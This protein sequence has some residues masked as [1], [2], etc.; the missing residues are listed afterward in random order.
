MTRPSKTSLVL[1]GSEVKYRLEAERIAAKTP[2]HVDW[3]RFTV[4]RRNAPLLMV[5]P[6]LQRPFISERQE[7]QYL[8][9]A[10]RVRADYAD[11]YERNEVAKLL[12]GIPDCDH[13]APAQ[14]MELA[15][16]VAQALGSE[17]AVNPEIKKGHDFYKFR[18]AIE[19]S[20]AECGWVGFLSSGDSPRQ[21]A[22]S[23]TIHC[24]LFGMACTF[25]ENGWRDRLA[26]IVVERDAT[27]TRCDLA[28]DFFEGYPGGIHA[29][30]NAYDA[31]L[32]NISGRFLKC[33]FVGD[34]SERSKGGRSIYFGSKEAGKETNCYEKGDQLFG[35]DSGS[36]WLRVELR[37][38][39][40]LRVLPVDM[41]RDPA[42]FFAGASDW[43]A[44]TLAL[45]DCVVVPEPVKTLG[46]LPLET[47]RAECVRSIK[48]LMGTAGASAAAA[49]EFLG[50]DEFCAVVTNKK[51]PG[52][53]SKFSRSE[54]RDNYVEAFG[55]ISQPEG[56]PTFAMA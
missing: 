18:W 32:C 43:H 9:W 56:C 12:Q 8:E 53:L 28:L 49:F 19:R 4:L 31:G 13:D 1:D 47:I 48:W 7:P 35:V 33:N 27:L 11:R 20:G 23:Q 39:N 34:W 25:A 24:N 5:E 2:V 41:L 36:S 50:V 22:Q 21:K 38:G 3:V 16:L 14:A 26:D 45:A 55:R 15:T 54:L 40:K 44:A 42:S 17:F 30:R 52:R 29:I 10:N 46:R 37:Y 51:L 6:S